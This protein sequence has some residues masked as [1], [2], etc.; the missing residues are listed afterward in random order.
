MSDLR[1][2]RTNG[3]KATPLCPCGWAGDPS[4]RCR[5]HPEAIL[6]YRSKISGPLLERIDLHVEVPRLPPAELRPDAP[7]GESSEEVR[8]RVVRAR[9]AQ[10]Q[11]AGALNARLDQSATSRD[12][13][14]R[15]QDQAMLEAAIEHLQLSARSMHRILRVARTI[16]DLAGSADILSAH[17]AEAIGYRRGERIPAS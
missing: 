6:R 14:L 4:G 10:L 7:A 17:V 13:R 15:P 2:I 5:C 12:C 9:D 11:R 8:T 1:R 16:A 3:K